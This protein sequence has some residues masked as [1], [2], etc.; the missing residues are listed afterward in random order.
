MKFY[1][2]TL[3]MFMLASTSIFSQVTY[4]DSRVE[5]FADC[6]E[7]NLRFEDFEGGPVGGTIGITSCGEIISAAGDSCF[8]EGE[9]VGG[10]SIATSSGPGVQFETGSFDHLN[11]GVGA[12][13]F[14][15]FSI[16]TFEDT[17]VIDVSF[18]LNLPLQ[19]NPAPVEIRTF[20]ENGLIGARVYDG[21]PDGPVFVGIISEEPIV[22][23]EVQNLNASLE[24]ISL[25]YFGNCDT[26]TST[27]EIAL[28]DYE[29]FP[30]PASGL[31][32]LNTPSS[33]IT[34]VEL[35]DVSGNLVMSHTAA[36]YKNS[37]QLDISIL[38][39]GMYF[40]EI[41]NQ[42]KEKVRSKILKN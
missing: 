11:V 39:Q 5:F 28:F 27:D 3:T 4:I 18:D 38:P 26:T 8:P 41:T 30:N 21:N 12:D 17:N 6:P 2:L 9:I 14:T 1:T 36:A 32:N 19:I 35:F 33:S 13:Q 37:T 24:T 31:I 42:Q 16:I 40:I 10:F 23:I 25:L 15:A 34:N 22:S 29:V 7:E 20:G